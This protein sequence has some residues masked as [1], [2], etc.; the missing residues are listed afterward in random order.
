MGRRAEGWIQAEGDT[1][2]WKATKC[3]TETGKANLNTPDSDLSNGLLGVG[4]K[5]EKTE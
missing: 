2:V 5:I 1:I 4:D 3:E